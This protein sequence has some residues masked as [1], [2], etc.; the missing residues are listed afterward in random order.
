ME[1][2][3]GLAE[4]IGL[5]CAE[6]SHTISFSTYIEKKRNYLRKNKRTEYIQFANNDEKL[7]KHFQDLIIKEYN[8]KINYYFDRSRICKISIIKDII[9]LTELGHLKWRVPKQVIKGNKELKIKFLR[10]YFDG[11]GTASGIPRFFSTN[12][13]GL[14]QVSKML[15]N[16]KI[17]HTIQGPIIKKN[18][19]PSYVLQISR[20]DQN[21]F[22][23]II[24]PI[25]KKPL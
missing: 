21:N 19:K 7:Q 6:G 8:H 13:Q 25:S 1:I 9:N 16:F 12:Q 2:T 22:F 11:D 20:K 17:R 14:I 18:K 24:N 4:I 15:D 3:E 23:R 10:G 5:L